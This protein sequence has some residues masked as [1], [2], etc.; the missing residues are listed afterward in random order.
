MRSLFI[1]VIIY[2]ITKLQIRTTS[3]TIKIQ[4]NKLNSKSK[5]LRDKIDNY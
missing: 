1:Q 4:Q 5:Q 2:L 3:S